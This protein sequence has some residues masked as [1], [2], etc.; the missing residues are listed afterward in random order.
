MELFPLAA[1]S[2]AL[3]DG[4]QVALSPEDVQMAQRYGKK[5][6]YAF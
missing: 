6:T 1:V 4:T 3:A 5:S 2:V